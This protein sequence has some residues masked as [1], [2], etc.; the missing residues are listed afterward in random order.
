M[1][2]L[3]GSGFPDPSQMWF[4]NNPIKE[5][6]VGD[7]KIWPSAPVGPGTDASF[8]FDFDNPNNLFSNKGSHKPAITIKPS[9]T[10]QGDHAMFDTAS[11]VTTTAA[12]D[13]LNGYSV[14]LWFKGLSAGT[15]W[16]TLFYRAAP[17]GTLTNET[18]V[19]HNVSSTAVTVVSGLKFGSVHKEYSAN[20]PVPLS[21]DWTHVA[22]VWRRTS[23]TAFNCSIFINAVLR[24]SFNATGYASN[25]KFST[26]KIF[27]GGS[28]TAGQ[29]AGRMDDLM[30][31]DR[32]LTTA[33]VQELYQIGRS[34]VPQILTSGPFSFIVGD[35]GGMNLFADFTV[36]HWAADGLPPG[37]TLNGSSGYLSGAATLAGS[38]TMII[39]AYGG[40]KTATKSFAWSVT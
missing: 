7:Q 22:V 38:G 19:V 11:L 9:V 1:P 25:T 14:S 24:G 39:A 31:W 4:G 32:A 33:E 2:I 12:T 28:R 20:T 34:V 26:E 18:Y 36:E 10:S 23:T 35:P 29:W 37:I 6:W 16:K 17:S 30:V 15:G 13:W 3:F 21:A 8:W 5:V 40:G 27:I